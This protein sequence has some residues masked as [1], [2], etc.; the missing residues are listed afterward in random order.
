M[1][2]AIAASDLAV[3]DQIPGVGK[4][5]TITRDSHT[6]AITLDWATTPDHVLSADHVVWI[7][8]DEPIG[9]AA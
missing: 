2:V 6:V 5:R 9:G 1:R 8:K 7:D 4:V 3:G